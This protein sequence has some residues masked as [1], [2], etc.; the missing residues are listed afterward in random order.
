MNSSSD[1]IITGLILMSIPF[2]VRATWRLWRLYRAD[3]NR[4]LLLFAL[5][6]SAALVTITGIWVGL[7]TVRRLLGF[8]P[9]E[10]SPPVT[11]L[12]AVIIFW[13]P[14]LFDWVVNQIGRRPDQP[15]NIGRGPR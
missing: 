9:L 4:S 2:A 6:F 5:A 8:E 15:D 13:I 1:L 11:G 12:L 7:L 14:V 10:W 3:T